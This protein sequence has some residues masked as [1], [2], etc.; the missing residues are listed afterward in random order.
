[1]TSSIRDKTIILPAFLLCC[2][3]VLVVL[4]VGISYGDSKSI[5]YFYA[6]DVIKAEEFK[7]LIE[8]KSGGDWS[9]IIVKI[10]SGTTSFTPLIKDIKNDA[11]LIIIGPDTGDGYGNWINRMLI[12]HFSMYPGLLWPP[13]LGIGR[14]GADFFGESGYQ[15]GYPNNVHW[16]DGLGNNNITPVRQSTNYTGNNNIGHIFYEPYIISERPNLTITLF[17]DTSGTMIKRPLPWPYENIL[18]IGS[19]AS[20]PT[21]QSDHYPLIEETRG[22]L[23]DVLWGFEGAPSEM[24]ENG[25]KLYTNVLA[26]LLDDTNIPVDTVDLDRDGFPDDADN[27]PLD[28]NSGQE[29]SDGDHI[30]DACDPCP[31]DPA[32]DADDDGICVG[33]G[34]N[35]GTNYSYYINGEKDNCPVIL[36]RGQLDSDFDEVGDE[37]DNCPDVSNIGQHDLDMDGMGDLC[38][39]DDDGDGVVDGKDNCPLIANSTQANLDTDGSGDVCDPDRDGDGHT[40]IQEVD[41]YRTDPSDPD[42]DGDGIYDGSDSTPFGSGRYTI[43]FELMKDDTVVSALW[44][45]EYG[46]SVITVARLR[47]PQLNYVPFQGDVVFNLYPRPPNDP[48]DGR[49]LNEKDNQ[50]TDASFDPA[51]QPIFT[52]IVSAS[53]T[54]SAAVTLF[55]FDY[56]TEATVTAVT[57]V[58]GEPVTGSTTVPMDSDNDGVPDAIEVRYGSCGFDRTNPHSFTNDQLDGETDL[59]RSLDDTPPAG[60]GIPSKNEWRGVTLYDPVLDGAT[61]PRPNMYSVAFTRLDPCRK[62]L[63]VRGDGF[64]NSLPPASVPNALAFTLSVDEV[65]AP[66]SGG[67]NALEE[68]E[69]Q[70]LDVTGLSSHGWTGDP[71][72]GREPPNTNIL[73]VTYDPDPNSN[74]G[75]GLLN[76]LGFNIPE[77]TY[78]WDW[79][80]MGRSYYGVT[81]A[82][83]EFIYGSKVGGT[84]VYH[85]NTMHYFYNRPYRNET[86]ETRTAY[87]ITGPIMNRDY[88]DPPLL[89]PARL[90][91]DNYFENGKLDQGTNYNEDLI[92]NYALDGDRVQ[93]LDGDYKVSYHHPYLL[94]WEDARWGGQPYEAGYDLSVFDM[95]R[96]G[97]VENPQIVD[98]LDRLYASRHDPGEYTLQQKVTHTIIHEIFH[99]LGVI[100][101]ADRSCLMNADSHNWKR[102]GHVSSHARSQVRVN[103]Q[104]E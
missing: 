60:D 9:T 49:A 44:L 92:I 98:P 1:M 88:S 6:S 18:A 100:E 34:F 77:E 86:M 20:F 47:D 42:T 80:E 99:S 22:S 76:H 24:T 53:G 104:T 17:N 54:T 83:G 40:N 8:A 50:E 11:D 68:I 90:I 91:E 28:Y 103:N 29:D 39:G 12:V 101:A 5:Y 61:I 31:G 95:D 64:S 37:C 3:T 62:T 30:G 43:V 96:D 84:F 15:I 97:R 57:E 52:S 81:T 58:N 85:D 82:G 19:G 32:N 65:I 67:V 10:K 70:V 93:A 7:D 35:D 73:V 21:P 14:G 27:C 26:Y 71:L 72:Q 55:S 33:T 25:E 46:N 13:T 87:G 51:N 38:D 74:P 2:S 69:L 45:P 94:R 41:V 75:T 66:G 79:H 63:F 78:H 89:D 4:T 36:N 102:A 48:K 16:A 59:D 23:H 56:G